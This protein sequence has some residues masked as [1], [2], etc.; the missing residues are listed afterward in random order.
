MTTKQIA[1]NAI[2]NLP[3]CA[4]WDDIQDRIN[5][6]AGVQKSLLALDAGKGVPHARVKEE[7]AQWLDG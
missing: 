5:F 2:E 3:D 4:S 1:I 6:V 7:F